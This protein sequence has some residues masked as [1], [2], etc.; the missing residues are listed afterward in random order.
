MFSRNV[1][2]IDR[3]VRVALGAALLAAGFFLLAADRAHGWTL[4]AVGALALASGVL[5]FCPPYVLFG[6]ST[7]RPRCG[8]ARAGQGRGEGPC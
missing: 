8:A 1:G 2:G 6:L 4:A 7:A 3:V 5:G